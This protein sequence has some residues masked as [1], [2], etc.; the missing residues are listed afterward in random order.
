MSN[1][2]AYVHYWLDTAQADYETMEI[3]YANRQF[4]WTLFWG[5]L[6][7]EKTLKAL[8]TQNTDIPI[9]RT[10]DLMRLFE[11]TG[12]DTGETIKD[13]LD[14]ITTFNISARYPDYKNRFYQS[15]TQEYTETRI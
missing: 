15:C 2:D 12:I 8:L 9:P 10:H 11:I 4:H 6:V 14:V 13:K 5:H 3:M 1:K 7:I